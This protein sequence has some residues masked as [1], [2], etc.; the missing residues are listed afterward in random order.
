MVLQSFKERAARAIVPLKQAGSSAAFWG[1]RSDAG[2]S[3]PPYYL[4]YFL[5]IDLLEFEDLGRSEK[6][7][8][9]IPIEF[10]KKILMIEYRKFGLGI[11]IKNAG[12][13]KEAEEVAKKIR[14]GVKAARSYFEF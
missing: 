1:N 4:V 11:F 9:S 5:F 12:D 2:R 3:L 13:E 8:F 6:V 7:A 10:N 14:S